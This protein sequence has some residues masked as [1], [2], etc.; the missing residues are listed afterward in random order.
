MIDSCVDSRKQR[1][2]IFEADIF[3][4]ERQTEATEK[5]LIYACQRVAIKA[6]IYADFFP[7]KAGYQQRVIWIGCSWMLFG[8]SVQPKY[9]FKRTT[10]NIFHTYKIHA[11]EWLKIY[12]PNLPLYNKTWFPRIWQCTQGVWIISANH[13]RITFEHLCSNLSDKRRK[14]I[15]SE[16]YH[17]LLL[18]LLLGG[19]YIVY[20]PRNKQAWLPG[21]PLYTILRAVPKRHRYF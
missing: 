2:H 3:T 11:D 9:R 17:F 8:W 12:K 6:Q 14:H 21:L 5:D 1:P 16:N 7:S 10:N 20:S 18:L 13:G 19:Q 15:T 4:S